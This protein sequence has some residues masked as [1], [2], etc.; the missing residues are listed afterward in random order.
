MIE[1]RKN[2]VTICSTVGGIFFFFPSEVRE[3][4]W[5]TTF[6]RLLL[7]Q[8]NRDQPIVLRAVDKLCSVQ[9]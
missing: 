5:I 1:R 2:V 7:C 6:M 4:H 9:S 3:T 8:H